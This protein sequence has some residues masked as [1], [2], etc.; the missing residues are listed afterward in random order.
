MKTQFS[1]LLALMLVFI[2]CSKD[3]DDDAIRN[4]TPVLTS[5]TWRVTEFIVSGSN[6]T[7]DFTGYNF[8]FNLNGTV[9]AVKAAIN[10]DGSWSFGTVSARLYIDFGPPIDAIGELTDDWQLV[11]VADTQVKLVDDN[12]GN[13]ASL[14]F[15]KN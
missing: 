15:T 4:P 7:A 5:G 13:N 8:T 2:S 1:W 11:S 10:R 14:V 12:S 6:E 9:T 3:D